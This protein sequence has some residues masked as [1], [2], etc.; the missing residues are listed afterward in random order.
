MLLTQFFQFSKIEIKYP[1][2]GTL[3]FTIFLSLLCFCSFQSKATGDSVVVDSNQKIHFVKAG[4]T[5]FSISK[6]Y[7]VTVQELRTAN[8]FTENEN[9][10][11]IGQVIKIPKT[12]VTKVIEQKPDVANYKYHLIKPGETLYRIS[13]MY[14]NCT[15]EKLMKLNGLTVN[16]IREGHYLKIEKLNTEA[17]F[18]AN[19]KNKHEKISKRKKKKKKESEL[20]EGDHFGDKINGNDGQATSNNAESPS[21]VLG[22]SEN[23]KQ[24]EEQ[25]VFEISQVSYRG[26]AN[27]LT[28]SSNENSFYALY[29]DSEIGSVIQVKNLLNNKK[30]QVKVIGKIPDFERDENI[31][32]KLSYP[33]AQSLQALDEKFVVEVSEVM[34]AP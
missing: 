25:K 28:E 9:A 17:L 31:L 34:K 18:A 15:V 16:E 26:I 27:Y 6:L 4:E 22:E 3:A 19:P 24:Q 30:V 2:N 7:E 29:D 5:L 12:S 11:N 14:Q 21:N 1:F 32:I 23:I 20:M 8:A 13:K 10:L 33:A